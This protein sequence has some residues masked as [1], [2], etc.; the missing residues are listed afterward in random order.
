MTDDGPILIM[1][2]ERS[3]SNLLRTLL[4]NH[5][6]IAGPMA[7]QFLSLFPQHLP[8]FEPLGERAN[9]VALVEAMLAIANHKIFSW[10]MEADAEALVDAAKPEDLVDAFHMLYRARAAAD[11]ARRY[12]C[13]ENRLFDHADE[14]VARLPGT[15][16]L[17]LVRDPRDYVLSWQRAPILNN[18]PHQAACAWRDE[19]RDCLG[20]QERLGDAA[21]RVTYEELVADTP[22]TMSRVLE[23]LGEEVDPACFQVEGEKNRGQEWSSFWK[24]LTKPVQA[25]NTKKYRKDLRPRVIE[26][27]DTV[28]RDE[29]ERLGYEADSRQQWRAG[30]LFKYRERRLARRNDERLRAEHASTVAV[31]EDRDAMLRGMLERQSAR[32]TG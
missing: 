4:S 27:I 22:G 21:M 32:A 29:M 18:T 9:M 1:S 12:V 5:E 14:L 11:G 24:N 6:A 26:M 17:Y 7:A 3:G 28:C 10:G 19:Q 15:R 25:G 30:P 8:R 31:I 2:S 20:V 16:V 13:K 23:F